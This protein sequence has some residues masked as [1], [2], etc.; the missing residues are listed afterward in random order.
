MLGRPEWFTYRSAGWGI[1]ARTWQGWVYIG[2]FVALVAAILASPLPEPL[3]AKLVWLFTGV[4]VLDCLV[5]WT[6]L[7]RHHDER[8]RLH[9]L[10][11]ERNC[12]LAAVFSVVAVMG[13]QV[14]QHR[15]DLKTELPFDPLLFVVLGAMVLTKLTSTLYLRF[16]M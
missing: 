10:I 9:Q 4:F 2:A 7:G 3:K 6:Q 16:R 12:S 5:I 11:I 8:E 1:A 14:F 15:H 13:Y